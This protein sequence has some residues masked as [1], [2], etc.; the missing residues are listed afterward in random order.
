MEDDRLVYW[1]HQ[2]RRGVTV[3]MIPQIL[4]DWRAEREERQA[5]G[6]VCR[7]SRDSGELCGQPATQADATRGILVCPE[8]AP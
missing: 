1:L 8:H 2:L 7:A 6:L 3:E 4:A 5:G